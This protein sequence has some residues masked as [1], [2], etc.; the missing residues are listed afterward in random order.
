[1]F[2]L[3]GTLIDA[4]WDIADS[5]NRVLSHYS[6]PT[7][8]LDRYRYLVGHG[9]EHLIR[10]ALGPDHQD[11]LPEALQL[12]RTYYLKHMYDHTRPYEGIPELLDALQARGVRLAVLSNKPHNATVQ[13]VGRLL[14]RWRFDQVYGQR[15][16]V[17][18]KPDP[19]AAIQ[20]AQTLAI[21]PDQW[22]YVG[23]TRVD[24]LTGKAAGMF[25][26]GVTWGFRPEAELRESH[27][28]AIIHQPLQ[29]LEWL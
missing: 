8:S 6:L 26:V 15:E 19:A 17:P 7:I 29:L 10:Q 1:M 9:A 5:A 16:G 12:Y 13:I 24:M 18:I 2:D 20:I 22:L 25:T 4:L 3:D 27:A 28:D 14:E 23:D 21:P 11:K